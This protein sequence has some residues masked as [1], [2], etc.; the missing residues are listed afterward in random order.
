LERKASEAARLLAKREEDNRR[1]QEELLQLQREAERMKEDHSKEAQA[2]LKEVWH[3]LVLTHSCHKLTYGALC[4]C[5]ESWSVNGK[6]QRPLLSRSVQFIQTLTHRSALFLSIVPI[7]CL[8]HVQA[9]LDRMRFEQAREAEEAQ[10]LLREKAH[11][12]CTE[13]KHCVLVFCFLTQ[14]V[15]LSA[16]ASSRCHRERR[17]A[18]EEVQRLQRAA[19]VSTSAVM[20]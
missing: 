14:L 12:W 18:E 4:R 17:M 10:R 2:L 19:E 8:N 5:S 16:D 20:T 1:S 3:I 15:I 6:K 7:T 9:E 11:G 13:E